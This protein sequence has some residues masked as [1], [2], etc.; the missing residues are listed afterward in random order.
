MSGNV[1]GWKPGPLPLEEKEKE[2][3][4]L[5]ESSWGQG[6]RTSGLSPL[7]ALPSVKWP[8]RSAT[9]GCCEH[10]EERRV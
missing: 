4:C 3:A 9:Y 2:L 5:L 8:V 1:R 7:C 6:P 10:K